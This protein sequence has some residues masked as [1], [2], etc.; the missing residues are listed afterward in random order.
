MH[1]QPT[2]VRSFICIT[3]ACHLGQQLLYGT[4]I[5]LIRTDTEIVIATDSRGIDTNGNKAKDVCKIR[6]AGNL[7]FSA[8]GLAESEGFDV[9]EVVGKILN[10]LE[11]LSN[12]SRLIRDA[13]EPRVT[14]ALQTDAMVRTGS[15]GVIV[16]GR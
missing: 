4:A 8:H 12:K 14:K 10:T 9:F 7:F 15:T 13:V 6:E 3:V 2:F 1:Y 11:D 5:A 16:F